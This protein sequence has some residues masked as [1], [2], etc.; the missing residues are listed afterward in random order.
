[1]AKFNK[2]K[3]VGQKLK[4]IGQ[5]I[6]GKL[7]GGKK[8]KIA[9]L[10]VLLAVLLL[11]FNRCGAKNAGGTQE[12]S[13]TE[14]P[15]ERRTI[16]SS[17]SGSGTLQPANSYTVTTLLEGEILADYFEEG[18]VIEKDAVLYEMDSSDAASNIERAQISLRQAERNYQDAQDK[19][20]VRSDVAGEV[21]ELNVKVG[22]VVRQGDQVAVIRDSAT[23]L[24][25]VP[26]PADD[27][28]GFYVG[29]S[30]TVT[31]DG[32]FEQISGK[33]DSISGS[34]IVG[35]GNMITRNVTVAVA[36]P[37][38]IANTQA[39]TASVGGVQCAGGGTFEYQAEQ[40]VTAEAGGTVS[41]L[42]VSEGQQV[43][44]D[45][46][47]VTLSGSDLTNQIQT[48][49]DNLRS[50]QLSMENTQD[51]MDNYTISSPISGT[52]V[53]KEYKAGDTIEGSKTLCTIYDL[54]YLE[55]T[56]NVDELDVS[57]VE[58]GQT[59]QITAEAVEGKT[60]TGT[61]TKV[62]VAGTTNNG[63]TSYPVTI[64]LTEFDGL[65]PGMNVEAEIVL[66]SAENTLAVPNAAVERGDVVL[67][68]KD[69]P[70]AVNAVEG[71]E[72]P[73]GYVYVPVTTGVSDDDYI[74][75]TSGLA[76]GDTVAYIPASGG[77]DSMMMPGGMDGGMGGDPGGGPGG[78]AGG[79]G[80]R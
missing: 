61:V 2:M 21:A 41:K 6:W 71:R 22:D 16:A 74:A 66:E 70:S 31:L 37:G 60:Y 65:L 58:V 13:Y 44:V 10:L 28:K 40:I 8:T 12:A 17:L 52:V 1:M 25:T 45:T 29:E 43:N 20:V 36:N 30:A 3:Q 72:A 57:Q 9:L 5:K 62:S 76:E 26:F 47:L 42:N 34:D 46:V 55:M 11:A 51:Q 18:D 59:A 49:S 35:Q 32:T 23:M 77:G 54:S 79:G 64:Q 67:V 68:T 15:V 53:S 38:G 14:A 69:S 78:G 50:A 73:E 4:Q 48:A 39:A 56:L 33:V 27:A 7:P 24:L 75:I 63:V 80:P 19:A